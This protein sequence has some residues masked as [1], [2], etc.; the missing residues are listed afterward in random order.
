MNMPALTKADLVATLMTKL[1]FEKKEAHHFVKL[2]Y[3][4]FVCAFMQ[5]E[6]VHLSGFGNFDLK[7][8]KARPGR[9]PKT[10]EPHLIPARRVVTFHAGK[11]LKTELK[12]SEE[13]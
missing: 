4:E 10:K 6:S 8:K 1:N 9:N 12:E 13:N 11:K 5:G 2:F 7:D 3:D